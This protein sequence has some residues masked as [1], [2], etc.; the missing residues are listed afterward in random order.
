MIP[1]AYD[2]RV[3][4]GAR[5]PRPVLPARRL[6][7]LRTVSAA[8]RCWHL[9][10]RTG[11]A[12]DNMREGSGGEPV[13]AFS[14]SHP[15]VPALYMVLTLGLTMFS[16]QPVLIALSLAG[17]LAYGFATRG[18][19]RTLGALRWQLPVIL[20]I[21]L[22]NPLFSASGSTEL[23]RIGMRAVHLESLVYGLCMGG[24]FVA[25]VLWFEAAASMLEYDKVLALL[26]NAA[27]V[28]ALMISMCMR[29]IP[30]FLRRGR[31][32]LA[33][34]D[35][36]DMPGRK[37]AD[38][39]R[40]RLRASSVLMGWGMEDSLERADAMRSRGWGAVPRRTT[41]A[42][43]RLGRSDVTALV[44]LALFGAAAVAVAW[45]A[46][47][48]YSFYPQLSVPAPWQG[49]VVYAV[50]MALPCVLCAIDEKRFG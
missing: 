46:T 19:V 50:W 26:G 6:R 29:L 32:V 47:T 38:P 14:M 7:C 34:Q 4:I 20:I 5:W 2:E 3:T 25:S 42:R 40:S 11:V 44:G 23:F 9:G 10:E 1:Q 41:Y 15:A 8:L 21:A 17:G 30:Q 35:A 18:T 37:P 48:Q 45:T 33:V 13:A 16:M 28:I 22:V 27:P 36:I 31:T 12:V 43:Y 24:L 49:Y 39:V